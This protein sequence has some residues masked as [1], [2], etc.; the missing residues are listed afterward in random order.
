MRAQ[1]AADSSKEVVE[2]GAAVEI[3]DVKGVT[4]LVKP[5]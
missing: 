5:K 3:V 2:G 1:L 4:L